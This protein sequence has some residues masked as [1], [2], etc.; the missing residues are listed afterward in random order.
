M[1][2]GIVAGIEIS[3]HLPHVPA[4]VVRIH[5]FNNDSISMLVKVQVSDSDTIDF[6]KWKWNG[7]LKWKETGT[8]LSVKME[9]N[10]KWN[11]CLKFNE[12]WNVMSVKSGIK[13]EK[14]WHIEGGVKWNE[15]GGTS[16]SRFWSCGSE[17]YDILGGSLCMLRRLKIPHQLKIAKN[18]QNWPLPWQIYTSGKSILMVTNLLASAAAAVYS[19]VD[20]P[21][22]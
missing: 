10:V 6:H 11:E 20:R 8:A 14:E 4:F 9:Q 12:K 22:Q 19:N 17:Q 18:R 7:G 5:M 21:L 13:Y 16:L 2:Q 15:P 1:V 3:K